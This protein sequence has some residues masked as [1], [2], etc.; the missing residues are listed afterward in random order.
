MGQVAV[1]QL[2]LDR[3]AK[4]QAAGLAEH[5][6]ESQLGAAVHR[7]WTHA[8]RAIALKSMPM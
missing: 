4:P 6:R 2:L 1:V 7:A 5:A 8:A 3:G